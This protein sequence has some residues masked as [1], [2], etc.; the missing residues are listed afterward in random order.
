MRFFLKAI[1]V[2][3]IVESGWNTPDTTIAEWIVFKNK[4]VLRMTKL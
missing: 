1:N 2:W 3:H 4:L